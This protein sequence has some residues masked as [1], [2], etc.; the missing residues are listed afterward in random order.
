MRILQATQQVN[1]AQGITPTARAQNF[2]QRVLDISQFL[3]LSEN[4]RIRAT[5][6]Q[7]RIAEGSQTLANRAINAEFTAADVD[8]A[9]IVSGLLK[10]AGFKL[11]FDETYETDLNLGV[12]I[13]LDRWFDDNL[14]DKIYD[15]AKAIEKLIFAGSGT[16]N[17]IEGLLTILDGTNVSGFSQT[18]VIDALTG[19][20][21]A[22]DSFDLSDPAN[23]DVFLELWDQWIQEV[24][25]NMLA[26][27]NRKMSGRLTT[28]FREQK[29][30]QR[31]ED[32]FGNPVTVVDGINLVVLDNDVIT[33]TEPDN[34]GTPN[35]DTTSIVLASSNE[36]MYSINTNSGMR[37]RDV[38]QVQG[39][40]KP[41]M[42]FE[43]RAK[44]EIRRQRAVRR[45]RN[46]KL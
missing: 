20:G 2:Y 15:T 17:E 5:E 28:I 13:D 34:N 41:S 7:S 43:F 29:T 8:P 35:T 6:H 33:N 21:L 40:A 16:S 36:A 26:Y 3:R 25:G 42:D 30:M 14:E 32:Q 38:G 22:G 46:I 10:I 27:V 31:S 9:A 19:S 23:Y 12:G 24:E 1:A 45:I 37:F 18:F 11:Q 4:F 39:A 44:N